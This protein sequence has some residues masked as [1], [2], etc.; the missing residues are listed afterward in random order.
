MSPGPC[1]SGPLVSG[2][3][4]FGGAPIGGLYAPVSH[5][6]AAQ[7]LAAAW[8]AGI[9]AFDERTGYAWAG[10][11]GIAPLRHAGPDG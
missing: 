10:A 3:L 7:T 1:V 9:R 5:E 11:H 6:A 4:V 2:P 8:E